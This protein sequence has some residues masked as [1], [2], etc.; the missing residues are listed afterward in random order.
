MYSCWLCLFTEATACA[1]KYEVCGLLRQRQW[2]NAQYHFDDLA[3]S[4][5][6][7]LIVLTLDGWLKIMMSCMA[8]T[9]ADLQP[10][11]AANPAA[12]FFFFAY[13]NI[14]VFAVMQLMIGIIFHHYAN[15]KRVR[16][17]KDRLDLSQRQWLTISTMV[18]N[19]KP[20]LVL[21]KPRQLIRSACFRIATSNWLENVFTSIVVLNVVFMALTWYPPNARWVAVQV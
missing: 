5:M 14:C 1:G 13:I 2:L 10:K 7:L 3:H 16:E 18:F 6:S 9:G 11:T 20:P 17:G 19:T 12:F 8:I 21:R 4:L 15:V